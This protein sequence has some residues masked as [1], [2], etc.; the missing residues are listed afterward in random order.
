M[1]GRR[2][3]LKEIQQAERILALHRA[4]SQSLA[5]RP[6]RFLH[7]HEPALVL[8]GGVVLGLFAGHPA[9][10]KVVSVLASLSIGIVRLQPQLL[11]Y[12]LKER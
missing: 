7:R 5:A 8:G 9:G 11:S 4:R 2:K 6:R 12:F 10:R 3:K 1:A